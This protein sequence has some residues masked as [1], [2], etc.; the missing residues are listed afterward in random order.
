MQSVSDRRQVHSESIIEA[1]EEEIV[2]GSLL[3]GER[4]D[5]VALA[6]RFGVSR[7][8]IR[9]ALQVLCGRSLAEKL[10]YKGVVVSKIDP[11]RIDLMF[12]AMAE[13]E[14]SCVRLASHRMTMSERAILVDLHE[15]M[16]ELSQSKDFISYE[17]DNVTFHDYLYN[18]CHNPE[19]VMLANSIRL[20]LAPFRRFQLRDKIRVKRSCGEHDDIVAAIMAQNP[21]AADAAV[22]RH[23]AS[24]AHEVSSHLRRESTDT[25]YLPLDK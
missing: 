8:P 6:T 5:E 17:R 9:E 12:E 10:P 24:A 4:I 1:L 22:R 7:T 18:G 11:T 16:T 19:L 21:K 3:P 25:R 13:V 23:L 14:A 15:R 2:S 20:K